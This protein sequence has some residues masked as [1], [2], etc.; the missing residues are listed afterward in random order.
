[1]LK[2]NIPGLFNEYP[3][4]VKKFVSSFKCCQHFWKVAHVV[5]AAC[6]LCRYLNS[7]LPYIQRH[8][9]V[10]KNVFCA[11]LNITVPSLYHVHFEFSKQI[12]TVAAFVMLHEDVMWLHY[13]TVIQKN[14]PSN[15]LNLK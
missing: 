12:L 15:N 8:I 4:T 13:K 11:S 2:T 7:S 1:M 5:A 3:H 6:F 9:T 14:N 10:T